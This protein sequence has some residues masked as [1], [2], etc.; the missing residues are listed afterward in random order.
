MKIL[1]MLLFLISL[2]F[3]FFL[4][5]QSATILVDGVSEWE[6]PS[7]NVGD[8][9]IFKH[10]YHYNLYIFRNKNAFNLCN[11]T[12]ATLLTKPN[13]TS[14]AWHPSRPGFFYFTFNNGSLKTC[15]GSQKLPIKVSPELPPENATTPSP[16][17]PPV[18]APAPTSG[19]SVVSS[20]PAYPWPFRPRQA[21]SPAPSASSP[22]TVP[23]L[24]P[25]KGGGIPFI[26]SNPAV[27]LPTGEV[28]S[29]TIRPLPTSAHGGQ[30]VVGFLAA[31]MALLSVALLGL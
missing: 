29:A 14:Y 21:V 10:K 15:Q 9:I 28:D 27:P 5:S 7:V 31:P 24:V 30:A 1:S 18:A 23:T 26:N 20:S 25:D 2:L 4:A 22:V 3:P 16:E 17:L 19:G 11:F 12:Q 6:N 13:S 8:S